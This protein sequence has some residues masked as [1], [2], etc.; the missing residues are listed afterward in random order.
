MQESKNNIFK[1]EEEILKKAK[2]INSDKPL[3]LDLLSKEYKIL[4]TA[5]EDLF[6]D[7]TL[8][9]SISDRFQEKYKLANDRLEEQA[10][11]INRI[12]LQ[13]DADNRSLKSNLKQINKQNHFTQLSEPAFFKQEFPNK[14]K[15][16]EYIANLKWKKGYAC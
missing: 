7:I 5:Y 14:E 13:L 8:L 11:I 1:V 15:C 2:L 9:T 3:D 4:T 12:N 16:L 6:K 10:N